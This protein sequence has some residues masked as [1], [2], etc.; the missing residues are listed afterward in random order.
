MTLARL[1]NLG[2]SYIDA[3][4]IFNLMCASPLNHSVFHLFQPN[5]DIFHW[6]KPN[7]PLNTYYVLFYNK[8]ERKAIGKHHSLH[9][10]GVVYIFDDRE[11]LKLEE[12]K[13]LDQEAAQGTT[14][15]IPMSKSNS[16]IKQDAW[17]HILA[18]TFSPDD[19]VTPSLQ[20]ALSWQERKKEGREM[21]IDKANKRVNERWDTFVSEREK[22]GLFC[23]NF[24]QKETGNRCMKTFQSKYCLQ[25][26]KNEKCPRHR[27]PTVNLMTNL[28]I[29][30]MKGDFAFSLATGGGG[31]IKN[32]LTV[33]VKIEVDDGKEEV[34]EHAVFS[35]SWFAPGFYRR[36]NAKRFLP[37]KSL[38]QDLQRLF[39]EGE[40]RSHG[41]S[42]RNASKYSPEMALSCLRNMKLQGS[43]RR[44][45][46]PQP[47]NINGPLPTIQYIKG[48]FSRMKKTFAD[49]TSRTNSSRINNTSK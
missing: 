17:S 29:C 1:V 15:F 26:H 39:L 11:G 3:K 35:H 14:T 22:A 30:H 19:H 47:D 21:K 42:K 40:D 48:K 6:P 31:T 24:I 2:H 49:P 4:D 25:R 27:F 20:S 41:G 43:G 46:S 36:E 10:S 44:K 32:R 33:G 34:R 8:E 37:T 12:N 9:G 5:R 18:S 23:C 13:G 16:D 7:D 45:Y 38:I 28:H